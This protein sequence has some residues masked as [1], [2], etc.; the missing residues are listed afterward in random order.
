MHNVTIFYEGR[1][2]IIRTSATVWAKTNSNIAYIIMGYCTYD[3]TWVSIPR[4]AGR[5]LPA[6]LY[7]VVAANFIN[8]IFYKNHTIV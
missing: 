8:N 6:S 5:F 7:F 4:P 1:S 2:E 3:S